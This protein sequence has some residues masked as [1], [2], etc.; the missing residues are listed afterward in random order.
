ML[1]RRF[2]AIGYILC[3]SGLCL[4]ISS[5]YPV[6]KAHLGTYLLSQTWEKVKEEKIRP[7]SKANQKKINKTD[8]DEFS[9]EKDEQLE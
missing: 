3:I 1:N 4:L 8:S 2:K 9:K 6:V 5:A 7:L